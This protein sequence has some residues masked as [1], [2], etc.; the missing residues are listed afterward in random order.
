[1]KCTGLYIVQFLISPYGYEWE[2]G[3]PD[4]L[5]AQLPGQELILKGV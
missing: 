2:V 3:K 4:Y 5:A 1:M